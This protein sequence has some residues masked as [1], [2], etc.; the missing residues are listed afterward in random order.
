MVI[1]DK[2]AGMT[3]HDVVSRIRRLAGTRRV[4]HAGTLDPMATGVLVIGVERATRLLTYLV[5]ADKAYAATMRL[6]IG[7]IT[8]D[9]EGTTSSSPGQSPLTP[10]EVDAA[11]EFL[12]GQIQQVPSSVSAIKKDGKR[13]YTRVREGEDVQLE[14]RP[15]TVSEL[16]VLAVRPAEQDG[17]PVLDVD[18]HVVCSSGTYIRALARD[19]GASLGSAGHL[20]ALR[21]TRV[22]PYRLDGA[23][24]LPELEESFALLPIADAARAAF[25]GRDLTQDE[26]RKLAH[27]QRL[28][29]SELGPG[30]VAAYAPDGSL[31]ALIADA[32]LTARPLVVLTG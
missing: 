9:A 3:S 8:D 4:G 24:T 12:R 7:T 16:S 23:H 2:P 21:R 5:G 14:A 6:G 29:A 30:P 25:T 15:V 13:A 1:V 17:T 11:A 31:V 27:G 10:E 22:G 26:A 32:G 28:E 19:L 18:V 20:T